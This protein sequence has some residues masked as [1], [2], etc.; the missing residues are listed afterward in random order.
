MVPFHCAEQVVTQRANQCRAHR[1]HEVKLP[2]RGAVAQ[3]G[4]ARHPACSE[5]DCGEAVRTRDC[6][7]CTHIDLV[8]A[9]NPEHTEVITEFRPVLSTQL[10]GQSTFK[11]RCQLVGTQRVL[12]RGHDRQA[13]RL[14]HPRQVGR[15]AG[16]DDV[17]PRVGDGNRAQLGLGL[18]RL[19]TGAAG[20]ERNSKQ[21]NKESHPVR[22]TGPRWFYTRQ[23]PALSP[24][25]VLLGFAAGVVGGMFGVGGG[26]VVVPGLVLWMKFTQH[27]A[28]GTSVATIIAS[29][30]AALV[31]FAAD[32]SVDWTAAGLVAI[33]AVTGA[34][35]GARLLHRIPPRVLTRAFSVLLMVAAARMALA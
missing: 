23:M 17:E 19:V 34:V 35:V 24:R 27:D 4:M 25:S 8:E 26:I 12:D 28:S 9:H 20:H 31:S 10:G 13:H 6:D 22:L 11:E 18:S 14:H 30:G 29:A 2:T 21:E 16:T 32:G 33:G 15:I 1:G 7:L 3:N 5:F